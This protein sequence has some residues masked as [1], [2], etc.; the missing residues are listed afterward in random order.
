MRLLRS[1]YDRW[2]RLIRKLTA[3]GIIGVINTALDY[4]LLNVLYDTVG[5]PLLIAKCLS[6]TVATTSSYF[7]NRHW[8]FRHHARSGLR[9]EYTLFFLFN[10][11]GLVIALAVLALF[12]YGLGLTDLLS[13]NIANTIGL[14]LGTVFRFWSYQKWVF[15]HPE[16]ALYETEG[17]PADAAA[18]AAPAAR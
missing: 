9:R 12:Q 14:V 8:T 3:F 17:D 16:D 18:P 1:L 10:G 13:I 11:V 5:I 7:M 4:V 6:V 15:R 2:H